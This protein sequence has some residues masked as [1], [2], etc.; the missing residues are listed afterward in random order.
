MKKPHYQVITAESAGFCFGVQKAVDAVCKEIA[1]G[2]KIHTYGPI[3]HNER[4]VSDFEKKGVRVVE[5]PEEIDGL[6]GGTLV[7]RSHGV[8]KERFEQI[9]SSRVRCIDATC[10]F[11]KRIHRIVEEESAKGAQIVIIGNAGHPE[12]EGIMGWSS[13]PAAVIGKAEEAESYRGDPERPVCV[14]SQTTF[15][16]EKFNELIA[17]LQ[18]RRYNMSIVNTICNATRERQEEARRIAKIADVMIV[19]GG[20]TSS[21]SAKLYEIC[22]KECPNTFFIQTV[23]DLA[24]ELTGEEKVIGITAGASTPKNIIEEVQNHVR[25]GKF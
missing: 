14:V 21:N 25:D 10:P 16:V 5:T 18:K 22:R 13:T 3:I 12:V 15:Q 7:I 2:E 8:S 6:T 9:Q 1:R 17:I 23:E 11:V 20:R 24:L 4:V 19:I